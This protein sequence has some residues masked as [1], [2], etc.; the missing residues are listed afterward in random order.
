MICEAARWL[1][2]VRVGV[3]V[4]QSTKDLASAL[5]K[6]ADTVTYIQ[7]EGVKQ[8]LDDEAFSRRYEILDERLVGGKL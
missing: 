2:G 1:D 6:S 7:R 3:D 4:E 5:S 8:R